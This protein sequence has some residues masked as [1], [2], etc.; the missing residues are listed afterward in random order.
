MTNQVSAEA[1]IDTIVSKHTQEGGEVL[2]KHTKNAGIT[3]NL[4]AKCIGREPLVLHNLT[5]TICNLI[6]A[7]GAIVIITQLLQ[8]WRDG[9]EIGDLQR[10]LQVSGLDYYLER[11]F[12]TDEEHPVYKV[13]ETLLKYFASRIK[14][15][16]ADMD[17]IG[18]AIHVM[19]SME[20][21]HISVQVRQ[22]HRR[23]QTQTRINTFLGNIDVYL[24][25]FVSSM[26]LHQ[27]DSKPKFDFDRTRYTDVVI[28]AIGI[29]WEVL[30]YIVKINELYKHF[31]G[32]DLH[33][34]RERPKQEQRKTDRRTYESTRDRKEP[35]KEQ[36]IKTVEK[37]PTKPEPPK[38]VK[39]ENAPVQPRPTETPKPVVKKETPK[40]PTNTRPKGQK[41][42]K[43]RQNGPPIPVQNVDIAALQSSLMS[44]GK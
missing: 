37:K 10:D 21:T 35:V 6:N 42:K 36:P 34:I 17:L 39:V 18:A 7:D 14:N 26:G 28:D 1:V 5:N 31:S 43:G 12:G 4:I 38:Q 32:H 20:I 23:Q 16:V 3:F 44:F 13:R 24:E 41:K 27:P 9:E 19:T 29:D 25:G 2:T 40:P 30:P 33:V 11:A 22:Q 15:Y 8:A